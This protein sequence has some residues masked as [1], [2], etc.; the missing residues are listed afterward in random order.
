MS[1]QYKRDGITGDAAI[2]FY[3]PPCHIS[4][5]R[6][7]YSR[8]TQIQSPSTWPKLHFRGGGYSRPTEVPQSGQIFIFGGWGGGWVLKTN[9]N[10][11]CQALT[12]LSFSLRGGV[13]Q[14]NIPEILEREHSRSFEY[15][16]PAA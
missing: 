10:P 15:K 13:V 2:S 5:G 3:T 1:A 12:K 14:T 6:G 7:G 8:P 16:I 11:K 9:S 4:P